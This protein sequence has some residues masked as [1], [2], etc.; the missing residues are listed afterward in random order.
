MALSIP[1]I[2]RVGLSPV[3]FVVC[4]NVIACSIIAQRALKAAVR[5]CADEDG[6]RWVLSIAYPEA[7]ATIEFH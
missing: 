2:Y 3:F 1:R 5:L 7:S 6:W 4:R